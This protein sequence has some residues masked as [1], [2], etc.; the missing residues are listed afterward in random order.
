MSQDCWP[1][2]IPTS[3]CGPTAPP[4]SLGGVAELRGAEAV[5]A[6]F[7]GKAQLARPA[8]VDGALGVVV[9][10]QGRLL[11]VLNLT[12]AGDRIASID[13]VAD[14]DRLEALDLSTLP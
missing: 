4:C 9:A 13:V 2:S 12:F 14:P 7:K 3:S 1:C 10:P 8:L 5:A 11:L 6:N